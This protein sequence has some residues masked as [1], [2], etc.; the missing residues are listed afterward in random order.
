MRKTNCNICGEKDIPV[1]DTLRIDNKIYCKSCFEQQFPDPKV[2]QNKTV[3]QEL[4]PTI[5]FSCN[6]DFGD[7]ELK[8][9]ANYPICDACQ[10][11]IKN[12]T[13][14]TWVKA[15]FIAVL[16]IVAGSFIWN[17]KYYQAYS[18]IMKSNDYFQQG[19]YNSATNLMHLASIKVPEVEDIRTLTSYFHGVDL[20]VKDSSAEALVE[21]NKCKDKLPTEYD[22]DLL[23]NQAKIGK[24]FNQKDYK[25]FLEATLESFARDSTTAFSYASVASAYACIYADEGSEN[26]K[27]KAL[28]YLDK[29][30]MLD[31]NDEENKEYVNRIEHRIETKNIITRNEFVERF[32]NGWT[33]N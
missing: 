9:I 14:P 20:L 26:A 23:I 19:D 32:P 4:D 5:C 12:R 25:G 18:Y 24:A 29:A 10:V 15:F 21:F 8:K 28:F 1:N 31:E 7:L 22:L 17:W 3:E 11:K 6:K 2:L 30:K 13:F 33:K 16:V 27:E